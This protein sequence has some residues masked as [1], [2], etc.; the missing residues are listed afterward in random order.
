[1]EARAI[2]STE[3]ALRNGVD[4]FV[5]WEVIRRSRMAGY[6]WFNFGGV[7]TFKKKF[8][9]CVVPIHCRIGG[10][11]E[12]LAPNLI[13][14]CARRALAWRAGLARGRARYPRASTK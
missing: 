8:G 12:W 14:G 3:A 4:P 1:V 6:T 10:G 9:G 13:E 5:I 7:T 11:V 2:G